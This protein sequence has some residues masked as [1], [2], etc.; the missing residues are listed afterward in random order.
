VVLLLLYKQAREFIN[1]TA[2]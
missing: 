2:W 1:P